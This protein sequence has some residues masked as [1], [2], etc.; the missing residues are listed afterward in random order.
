MVKCTPVEVFYWPATPLIG[1]YYDYPHPSGIWHLVARQWPMNYNGI[2][3]ICSST[4]CTA[5]GYAHL[6]FVYIYL[7]FSLI[8]SHSQF[9]NLH[10]EKW[11]TP[12]FSTCNIEK[13]GVAWGRGYLALLLT[14]LVWLFSLTPHWGAVGRPLLHL[15]HWLL[16]QVQ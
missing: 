7:V 13:S 3:R 11:T 16:L 14:N 6:N 10:A 15:P 1:L 4:Q 5:V 9:F 8:P 2:H 12:H